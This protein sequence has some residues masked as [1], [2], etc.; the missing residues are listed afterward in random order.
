LLKFFFDVLFV[1]EFSFFTERIFLTIKEFIKL[2][3]IDLVWPP[4]DSK[5]G[6][7]KSNYFR[8]RTQ[9]WQLKVFLK[10]AVK[11]LEAF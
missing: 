6:V 8:L 1:V 7:V 2:L 10:E 4:V 5:G 3:P 9:L 11:L